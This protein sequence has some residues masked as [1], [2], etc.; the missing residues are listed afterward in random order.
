METRTGGRPSGGEE[1]GITMDENMYDGLIGDILGSL[2]DTIDGIKGC[3]FSR[4]KRRLKESEK[5]FAGSLASSIPACEEA[6]AR[7]E[8]TEADEKFLALLP[9]LQRLGAFTDD[10]LGA[11]RATLEADIS[12][13]DKALAE[14]SEVMALVKDVARD[15]GDALAAGNP[16]FRSYVRTEAERVIERVDEAEPEH[17][18]R[19]IGGTCPLKASYLYLDMMD[20]LKRIAA[21]LASLAEKA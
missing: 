3:L 14:L 17:Q 2:G 19:L 1:A 7:K 18:Q 21:A 12:F 9:S 11:A 5:A 8:R 4:D 16:R 6:L 20:G 13:T 15:A 10:L